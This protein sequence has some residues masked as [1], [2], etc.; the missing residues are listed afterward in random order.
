[1]TG[2]DPIVLRLPR[3]GG[4]V[5]A[6]RFPDLDSLV[7]RSAEKAPGIQST[8]AFDGENGVLA[9][10]D[11]KGRSGWV[12]LRLGIIRQ[13]TKTPLNGT[14]SADGWSIYGVSEGTTLVRHTPT[15]DWEHEVKQRV[16]RI[17][18][19]PDG[20]LL[21]LTDAPGGQTVLRRVRPPE[22]EVTD[23]LSLGVPQ[24]SAETPLGD[25]LYLAVKGDLVAVPSTDFS[26]VTRVR[27]TDE[28]LAVAPTPS[29]DRIF[30]APR[31]EKSLDIIDR[32]SARVGGQVLL[33]GYVTEL[34]MDPLGRYLLV[35]PVDGDSAWVVAIA[36]GRLVGTLPTTWRGDLPLIAPDG[37]VGT[38]RGDDV[39]FVDPVSRKV[40][41][42]AE[43][44]GKDLWQIIHW[45]GFR[46]RSK[47]L[48]QPVVFRQDDSASAVTVVATPDTTPR[49]PVDTVMTEPERGTVED[50]VAKAPPPRERSGWTVSFA[51]VLT[52]ERAREIARDIRVD[53]NAARVVVS[54]TEGT[55]VFRV[56]LG[57]Y[58]SRQ[59]ADRVGRASGHS[60]WVF[61]GVP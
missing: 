8:L 18:P 4:T 14:A 19:Q 42:T 29:G 16:R 49:P 23:S 56:V 10:L 58:A 24:R 30:V 40:R 9:Y 51:A 34:R 26:G 20:S 50:T 13:A 37:S 6:F 7:W 60:Y 41:I 31:G 15:D 47:D 45:N 35:R 25:R 46:P 27:A 3:D 44:G 36:T 11:E 2:P 28:I 12:D 57:P 21:F 61:E 52:E 53:G 48:D 54:R 1:V 38:L 39:V 32:Y 22:S 5:R 43:D 55:S 17:F 33:P 59:E